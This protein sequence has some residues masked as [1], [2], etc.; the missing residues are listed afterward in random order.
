MDLDQTLVTKS[1][2]ETY[3]IGQTLADSLMVKGTRMAHHMVCLYGELGS[4]KTTFVQGFAKGLGISSRVLSPTFTIVRRYL[5]PQGNA[6]LYH[7]DLYKTQ[8]HDEL[9]ELGIDELLADPHS[10]VVIEW[11]D[12]LEDALPNARIDIR[13]SLKAHGGHILNMHEVV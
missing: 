13:F 6:F 4:G 10:Y 2:K 3:R 5:L 7:L 9:E 12:K 8:T 11:A 1:A